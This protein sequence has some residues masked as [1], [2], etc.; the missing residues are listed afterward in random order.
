[1]IRDRK[2]YG[3]I[4]ILFGAIAWLPFAVQKYLFELSISMTP[5]LVVHL[6]GVVPGIILRRGPE[7]LLWLNRVF[8]RRNK[9]IKHEI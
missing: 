8:F 9:D 6:L 7:S 5:Y 2:F 4:L 3:R 1:M